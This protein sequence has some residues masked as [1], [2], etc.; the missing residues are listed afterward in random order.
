MKCDSHSTA[1]LLPHYCPYYCPYNCPYKLLYEMQ[2]R[3]KKVKSI[4]Y[5]FY[6]HVHIIQ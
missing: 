2:T 1:P 4:K 5:T 6:T 3:I